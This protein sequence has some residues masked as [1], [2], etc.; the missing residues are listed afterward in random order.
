METMLK[1]KAH[2]KKEIVDAI[3][4]ALDVIEDLNGEDIDAIAIKIKKADKKNYELLVY[5]EG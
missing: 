2:S 4:K 1:F 3:T 5:K